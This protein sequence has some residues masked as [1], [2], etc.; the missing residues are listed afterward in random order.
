LQASGALGPFGARVGLAYERLDRAGVSSDAR[1]AVSLDLAMQL[2]AGYG[3][4]DPHVDLGGLL[5]GTASGFRG[6]LYVGAGLDFFFARA[7]VITAQ[8]QYH[9]LRS[10][11]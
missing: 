2:R 7:F 8:Y 4:I 1:T 11:S 6:A 5:G 3:A 10:P 9:M